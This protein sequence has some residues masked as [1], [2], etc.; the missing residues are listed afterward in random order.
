MRLESPMP[1]DQ[2]IDHRS[3][4][5][6]DGL[7][8]PRSDLNLSFAGV[9]ATI[10]SRVRKFIPWISVWGLERLAIAYL[11]EVNPRAEDRRQIAS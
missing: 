11:I 10:A 9:L 5:F 1:R 6:R 4:F 3:S 2:R 7:K 8:D